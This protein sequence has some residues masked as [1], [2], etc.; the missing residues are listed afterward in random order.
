MYDASNTKRHRRMLPITVEMILFLKK[1]KD[2]WGI[3]DI[4]KA[5]QNRLKTGRSER[6]EKKI[7]EN[8][9]EY[10]RDFEDYLIW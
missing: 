7:A 8:E 1:N 2:L 4:A 5:N 3:N 6:L 9:Q 10:I